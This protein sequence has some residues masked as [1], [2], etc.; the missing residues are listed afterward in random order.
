MMKNEI[1]TVSLAKNPVISLK[2]EPGHFTTSHF[3][4][5]HY[6]D[7]N[8][9]KTNAF[10]AKEVAIELAL[11]YMSTTLVDTIVC[12]EGT[13]VIGA[14]MASELLQE[15]T[16]SINMGRDINIVTPISNANKNLMIQSNKQDLINNQNIIVLVSTVSSGITI[17]SA[18]EYLSYYGGKIVGISALFNAY[19]EKQD[20]KIHSLFTSKDIPGYQLFRPGECPMCKVGLK[21]DAIIVHDGYIKI[22]CFD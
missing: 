9:L 11:P 17:G 4:A 19:P 16:Y 8:N 10:L 3:H 5:A 7:L 21:L 20:Q 18:L 14:Y 13:E 2:V 6:L 12:M 1:F 15:G 22:H